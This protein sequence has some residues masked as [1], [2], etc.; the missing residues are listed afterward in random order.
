[1][2]QNKFLNTR[3][4]ASS[5]TFRSFFQV[6]RKSIDW[7][8][9]KKSSQISLHCPE[10]WCAQICMGD[11][12]KRSFHFAPAFTRN[13]MKKKM[14][15]NS[16]KS[17]SGRAKKKIRSATMICPTKRTNKLKFLEKQDLTANCL[18][19]LIEERH[20]GEVE[21]SALRPCKRKRFYL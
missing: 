13:K 2:L 4:V 16:G 15:H 1:M 11:C 8:G 3:S 9:S 20:L 10:A 21:G 5:R 19:L 7:N 17:G 18:A 6:S 12:R 14:M